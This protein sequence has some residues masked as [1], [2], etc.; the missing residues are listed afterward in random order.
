[1]PDSRLDALLAK[2]VEETISPQEIAELEVL[3]KGNSQ[4]Q[5][6]YLHYLDLH[7]ELEGASPL[8][9]RAG[10]TSGPHRFALSPTGGLAAAA[11]VMIV[12]AL[13]TGFLFWGSSREKPV[14]RLV[15]LNGPIAWMPDGS[16]E[17]Q[18]L[19]EMDIGIPLISGTFETFAAGT[20]AKVEFSDGSSVEISGHAALKLSDL[21]NG[22]TIHLRK[23]QLSVDAVPQL[24]DKPMRL[25]TPAAEMVVLGTQFNVA[26]NSFS[27]QLTVNEGVVRIKRLADGKVLNVTAEH[28]AIAALEQDEPFEAQRQK[29]F[30][31]TWKSQ[32]PRDAVMGTWREGAVRALTHLYRGDR[33]DPGPVPPVLLHTVVLDPSRG[34]FPPVLAHEDSRLRFRG[35]LERDHRVIFGVTTYL[36]RGGFSGKY[37]VPREIEVGE[38][39]E[40]EVELSIQDYRR[41][42]KCFPESPVGHEIHHF[43]ILTLTE[44]AGLEILGGELLR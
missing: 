21:E 35:R 7:S 4:A 23:G 6:R 33:N 44:E 41:S 38:D 18:H 36:P 8:R 9:A 24:P 28:F 17:Y 30:A 27:T 31:D 32:L 16:D 5:T 40:F 11:A 10:S 34:D 29:R 25:T 12:A 26:A 3:L 15:D 14:A 39:G 22:K 20:W 43:W 37:S 2:L 13:L 42:K 1:M 19:Y